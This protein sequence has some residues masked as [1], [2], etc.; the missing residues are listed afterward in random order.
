MQ[1]HRHEKVKIYPNKITTVRIYVSFRSQVRGLCVRGKAKVTS[2][3]PM[4]AQRGRWNSS[5]PFATR[6]EK[7]VGGEQHA[8]AALSPGETRYRLYR[9]LG[10]NAST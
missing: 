1:L 4:H 10:G 9:R 2:D 3:T 6:H 5:S 7:E 8:P